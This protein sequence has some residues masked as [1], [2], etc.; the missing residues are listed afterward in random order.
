VNGSEAEK[1][2]AANLPVRRSGS[3]GGKELG[4]GGDWHECSLADVIDVKHGF[5]FQGQ[6]MRNEPSGNIVGAAL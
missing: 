3:E 5:A 1:L 6:F 4:Y 2:V